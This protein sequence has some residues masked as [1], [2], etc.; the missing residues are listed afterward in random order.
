MNTFE[1]RDA[2]SKLGARADPVGPQTKHRS[3][4][5]YS[6]PFQVMSYLYTTVI[7]EIKHLSINM[8]V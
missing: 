8:Y 3:N 4:F 2:S 7:Q 6:G 5:A 1:K